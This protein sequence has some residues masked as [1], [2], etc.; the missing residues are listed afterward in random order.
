MKIGILASILFFFAVGQ[1][2]AEITP[3]IGS[4]ILLDGRCT[5]DE[6]NDAKTIAS[7][8][9]HSIRMKRS[10]RYLF[11]CITYPED[12]LGTIEGYL[13]SENQ[14]TPLNIHVSAKI[15]DREWQGDEWSERVWWA[16]E[17]WWSNPSRYNSVQEGERRFLR[18]PEREI[19]FDLDYFGRTGWKLMFDF[20]Y[21]RNEDGTYDTVSLPAEAKFTD[22]NSW[23]ELSF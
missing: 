4:G 2:H 12:S 14:P 18:T 20:Y 5:D 6:W 17:G 13:V 7:N 10:D 21:G 11:M 23:F 19:Q 3:P 1:T 8:Q 15:G 16:A 22:Q 9:G